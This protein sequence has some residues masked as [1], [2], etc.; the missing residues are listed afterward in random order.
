MQIAS[1]NLFSSSF[2]FVMQN[3][4]EQWRV[5]ERKREEINRKRR[6]RGWGEQEFKR[7]RERK[8]TEREGWKSEEG[9]R[10][11]AKVNPR[12]WGS[13]FVISSECNIN[14]K[15]KKNLKFK[16]SENFHFLSYTFGSSIHQTH[17]WIEIVI[18]RVVWYILWEKS[19]TEIKRTIAQKYFFF[20]IGYYIVAFL[21]SLSIDFEKTIEW[22]KVR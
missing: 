1:I 16:R 19:W 2:Q 6:L 4:T 20:F 8:S 10:V 17:V 3:G 13:I 18:H 12:A 21:L 15:D 5:R 22:N 11:R 7:A 9:E 14:T